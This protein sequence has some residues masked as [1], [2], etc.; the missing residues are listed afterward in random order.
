MSLR[1]SFP[2]CDKTLSSRFCVRRHQM[3][4]D[5]EK[6][7]G[8]RTCG[9]RFSLPQYL[10]EHVYTHTRERPYKC[11]VN[12]CEKT[13]RQAGK[14][15]LHLKK[16]SQPAGT[17]RVSANRQRRSRHLSS[18]RRDPSAEHNVD[19]SSSMLNT[20]VLPVP[21]RIARAVSSSLSSPEVQAAHRLPHEIP[22]PLYNLPPLGSPMS[23]S[24]QALG[25]PPML[26]LQPSMHVQW[27]WVLPSPSLPP[28]RAE[29]LPPLLHAGPYTQL[30][31]KLL[32]DRDPPHTATPQAPV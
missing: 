24:T 29:P 17:K 32:F 5:T 13:F 26:P 27:P 2:G 16:H 9:K 23:L 20:R 18:S 30:G 7:H 14:L 1:C 15:S 3:T 11:S 12:G 28:V 4:H 21:G 19:M 25:V 8:C 31:V 22:P 10:K 6:K